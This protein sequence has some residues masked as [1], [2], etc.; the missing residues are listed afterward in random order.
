MKLKLKNLSKL[1]LISTVAWA[2]AISAFDASDILKDSQR[3]FHYQ[4]ASQYTH[5]KWP[6]VQSKI[7]IQLLP[8][9]NYSGIP[10]EDRDESVDY[11]EHGK[12]P[13]QTQNLLADLLV[14]SKQFEL[15]G[16]IAD[17]QVQFSIE[18]YDLPYSF[19]PDDKWWE[20]ASDNL[21]RAFQSAQPASVKLSIKVMSGNRAIKKWS[22][23]VRMTISQCDLNAKPQTLTPVNSQN[24]VIEN[25]FASSTGQSFLAASNFLISKAISRI[26]EEAPLASLTGKHG[27]EL[28]LQSEHGNF[29]L[30]E[31]LIVLFKEPSGRLN[32]VPTGKIKVV[33]AHGDKA[34]AFP[35]TVRGDHLKVG[36][37]FALKSRV[38][39]ENLKFH[40]ESN[41]KCA[42]V[43]IAEAN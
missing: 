7:S 30:G 20:K 10:T 16:N 25:Y 12:I 34:L 4:S 13:A 27:N 28:W 6:S 43:E 32:E 14:T 19:S 17:Y 29:A 21:D 31:E 22:D 42:P 26:N 23:S 15:R 2:G 38:K 33:K 39:I 24:G 3:D 5:I 36:D 8:T 37:Q 35:L 11:F 9:I 41:G 1:I 40:F 18:N